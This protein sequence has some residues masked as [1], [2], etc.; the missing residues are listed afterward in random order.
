[1]EPDNLSEFIQQLS[2]NAVVIGLES[3]ETHLDY[4]VNSLVVVDDILIA[5]GESPEVMQSEG[6]PDEIAA[7]FGAY[8]GECIRRAHPEAEW[9]VA[10]PEEGIGSLVLHWRIGELPTFGIAY[11]RLTE[12]AS[13]SLWDTYQ[14]ALQA[15]AQAYP[16]SVQLPPKPNH[17]PIPGHPISGEDAQKIRRRSMERVT[18]MGLKASDALPMPNARTNQ[19]LRPVEEIARRLMTLHVTVARCCAP[20]EAVPSTMIDAYVQKNGCLKVASQKERTLLTM[21]RIQAADHAGEAGWLLE[22]QWALAWVLGYDKAPPID[23]KML[24]DEISIDLRNSLFRFFD[25]TLEDIV[26]RYGARKWAH[27][28]QFEDCFY[29]AHNAYR[30]LAIND[31]NLRAACGVV[32]ERRKALT[33]AL[34]PGVAWDDTDVS[35]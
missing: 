17:D 16:D 15:I 6:A 3:F 26:A 11:M 1:M 19:S 22:N 7:S 25:A 23:G 31:H 21:D 35:T 14:I 9:P 13:H 8:A 34:S 32:Q 12:G 29:C 33:W 4:S 18:Q 28:V 20:E 10:F 24:P 27:V 2:E 5:F 30:S